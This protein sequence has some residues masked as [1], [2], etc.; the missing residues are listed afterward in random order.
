M[1]PISDAFGIWR[2]GIR[3]GINA[4]PREPVLGIKRLIL[5]VSYWRAVEFSYVLRR[6]SLPRG[7]RILDLGSPKDMAAILARKRGCEVVATDILEEATALS[8]R[9]AAAQRLS[10]LGP[11]RV[12]S[13]RQD[14]RAL[15]F[16]DDSFDAAFSISVLEH[17]P[18]RGDTAALREL[19]RVVKPGGLVV[20]TTPYDRQYRETFVD[21]PVYERARAPGQRV[22]FERHYDTATLQERL[23]QATNAQL[24]DLQLWGEPTLAVERFLTRS[25]WLRK[26]ISPMEALLAAL[27]LR[28]L[29]TYREVRPMAAFFTLQKP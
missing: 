28:P 21:G 4:L 14:G 23:L 1:T 15:T 11:G 12:R 26:L 22:F 19:V 24:V 6:L 7:S 18:D 2:A 9:Y 25:A 10:G 17:I 20:V 5:P 27:F 29:D 3:I 16:A 8:E 13:E